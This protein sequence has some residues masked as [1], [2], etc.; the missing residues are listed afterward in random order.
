LKEKSFYYFHKLFPI[1]GHQTLDPDPESGS[2]IRKNAESGSV[3]GSALNQFLWV[4]FLMPTLA[5]FRIR[6]R[7]RKVMGLPDPHP[8]LLVTRTDP[9]R[10][11]FS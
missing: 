5:V 6:I 1:L 4:G 2:A 7:I 10:S 3:F 8:D 9:D 11:F